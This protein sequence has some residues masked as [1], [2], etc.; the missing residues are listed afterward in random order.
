M[1]L[2]TAVIVACKHHR[3]PSGSTFITLWSIAYFYR[4][5]SSCQPALY[6]VG[7]R[8]CC[9]P[10]V[11]VMNV[12][13]EGNICVGI[14]WGTWGFF[15]QGLT[16]MDPFVLGGLPQNWEFS[17]A[18]PLSH[19]THLVFLVGREKGNM[20]LCECFHF[21]GI[22]GWQWKVVWKDEMFRGPRLSCLSP[23]YSQP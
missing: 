4:L 11:H 18:R 20:I 23:L 10:A 5:Q 15:E 14:G 19:T 22:G 6:N 8:L 21:M 2:F 13:C 16:K 7:G 12:N 9:S 3:T 17:L 1:W